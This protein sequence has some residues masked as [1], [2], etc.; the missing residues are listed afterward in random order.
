MQR[1][2]IFSDTLLKN[3][4]DY[5][6]YEHSRKSRVIYIALL[7]SIIL[8]IISLF[9]I[10]VDV[11]ATAQGVIKPKGERNIVTSP[12]SGKL[13]AVN[14]KENSFVEE[15]DTLFTIHS[16][17]ILSQLPAILSRESELILMLNDID[18]ILNSGLKSTLLSSIYIQDVISYNSQLRELEVTKITFLKSYRRLKSLYRDRVVSLSDFERAE[19]DY[20]NS[21][22][23]ISIF[24]DERKSQWNSDKSSYKGELRDIRLKIEQLRKQRQESVVLAPI[25]GYIQKVLNVVDGSYLHS[26]REI[27]EIS[28]SGIL[29]AEC[30]V[31][32]KDIGLIFKGQRCRVMVDAFNYNEWGVITGEISEIFDDIIITEASGGSSSSFY[33][34]YCNLDSNFLM[35]KN[36]YQGSIKKGMSINVRFIVARRTLFNL[37]YDKI[38]DWINPNFRLN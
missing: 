3:S 14:I 21:L 28:P 24:K 7:L 12:I 11:S 31:S 6:I 4:S 9:F 15:G 25:S 22:N 27:L 10:K 20:K 35:L 19:A 29:V 16:D 37:L 38:D 17:N 18:S 5:F 36:G 13:I 30:Y 2:R 23:A 34:V 33:K 32:P 8:S 26:G 1:P